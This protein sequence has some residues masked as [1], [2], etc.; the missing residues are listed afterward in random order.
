METPGQATTAQRVGEGVQLQFRTG[1]WGPQGRARG[2]L[3]YRQQLRP[4]ARCRGADC[5][6]SPLPPTAALL[7]LLCCCS[8][9]ALSLP[10]FSLCVCVGVGGGGGG[11]GGIGDGSSS[12]PKSPPKS[13]RGPTHIDPPPWCA[14][15]L[16]EAGLCRGAERGGATDSPEAVA[17]R[18]RHAEEAKAAVITNQPSSDTPMV[19]SGA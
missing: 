16:A 8:A 4:P 5:H 2:M 19:M 13:P 15:C 11:G 10:L 3:A 18:A 14:C 17:M 9:A 12:Q 6:P 1:A 7:L